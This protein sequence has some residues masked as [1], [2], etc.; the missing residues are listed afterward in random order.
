MTND[1]P[2]LYQTSALRGSYEEYAEAT[3]NLHT[4]IQKAHAGGLSLRT[5]ALSTNMSH[6]TVRRICQR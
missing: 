1:N 6:E 2:T 3:R 4:E 5:I